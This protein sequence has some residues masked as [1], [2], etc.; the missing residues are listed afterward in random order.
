[1]QEKHPDNNNDHVISASVELWSEKS[2]LGEVFTVTDGDILRIEETVGTNWS[3][4]RSCCDQD[5]VNSEAKAAFEGW[6][7]K[8]LF[9]NR[10]LQWLRYGQTGRATGECFRSDGGSSGRRCRAYLNIPSFIEFKKT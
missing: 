4:V 1:M 3:G 10:H 8:K 9:E 6:V 5:R 7:Q 2:P